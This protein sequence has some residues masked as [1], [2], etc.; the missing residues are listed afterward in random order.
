MVEAF[1]VQITYLEVGLH[2]LLQGETVM[3]QYYRILGMSNSYFKS[4]LV[5]GN[6]SSLDDSF[7]PLG[8]DGRPDVVARARQVIRRM[9]QEIYETRRDWGL[10]PP[11]QRNGNNKVNILH[12]YEF[13]TY[14]YDLI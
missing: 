3:I 1:Q 5:T 9:D 4:N 14:V 8:P 13:P 11:S 6:Q 2:L 10:L 12:S 7:I